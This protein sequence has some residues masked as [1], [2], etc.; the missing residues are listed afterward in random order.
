MKKKK[1]I[2]LDIKQTEE[3][4]AYLEGLKNW[5]KYSKTGKVCGKIKE[6]EERE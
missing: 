3:E 5:E 4:K 1:L 2:K 6:L